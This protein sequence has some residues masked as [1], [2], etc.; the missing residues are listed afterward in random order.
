MLRA[1]VRTHTHTQDSVDGFAKGDMVL[2]VFPDTTSF[3]RA[4]ISKPVKRSSTGSTEVFVQF[5]D[6][7]DET[8]RT[9]HRR[10]G[11]RFVMSNPDD[12]PDGYGEDGMDEGH[13]EDD[14]RH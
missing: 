14:D 1:R 4:T 2:A 10:V 5:E 6:D 3:Y 11:A 7:E 9:P 12:S 13:S 8:G